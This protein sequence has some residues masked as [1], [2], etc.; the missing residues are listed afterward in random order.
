MTRWPVGEKPWLCDA[1]RTR[2]RRSTINSDIPHWCF[3]FLVKRRIG[4]PAYDLELPTYLARPS[5]QFGSTASTLPINRSIRPSQTR[6]PGAIEVAVDTPQWRS[7]ELE[8]I[9]DKRKRTCGSKQVA[10][11]LLRWHS[12]GPEYDEWRSITKLGNSMELVEEYGARAKEAPL[13]NTSR[14]AP[15]GRAT[16]ASPTLSQQTSRS[17][18]PRSIIEGKLP[19]STTVI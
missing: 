3:A 10:Q 4:R 9:A 19:T 7:Y 15:K 11:Y 2:S 16:I 13:R 17:S 6:S 18:Q 5:G 8:R 14:K 1:L 12:Y